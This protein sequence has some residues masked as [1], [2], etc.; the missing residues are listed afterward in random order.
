MRKK[1]K[2]RGGGKVAK[3]AEGGRVG[4]Q[5][6]TEDRA[7]MAAEAA[8]GFDAEEARIM[9]RRAARARPAQDN[10]W[11]RGE[12]VITNR[13]VGA[14][15][16]AVATPA[17]MP[18]AADMAADGPAAGSMASERPLPTPPRPPRRAS[19]SPARSRAREMTA[20]DLNALSLEA[21][22]AGRNMYRKGGMISKRG[23]K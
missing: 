8:A 6:P 16:R 19:A 14:A 10:P 1:L 12:S 18:S 11:A 17:R 9:E 23:K 21:A 13:P 5:R 2:M 15:P 3:Y 4:G 20:D 22:R 7:R